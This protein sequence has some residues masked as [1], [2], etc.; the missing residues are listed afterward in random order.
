MSFLIIIICLFALILLITW[1]KLNEFLAFLLV[2]ILAA[3]L[4]GMPMSRIVTSVQ[5]GIGDTLGSLVIILSLGAMLGKLVAQSGAA[6]RIAA[7]LVGMFGRRYIQ[8]A[9]MLTGFIIGIPLFYGVGFVLMIPLIFSVS[10]Q[11]KFPAVYVGMPLL[12]AMSVTHGFLPPHPSPTALVQQFHANM[13]I[14]L[15]Y[16]LLIAVPVII[17]AGPVFSQSLKK[18]VATPLK[19]FQPQENPGKAPGTAVS[20]ITSLL[21]V[22]LLVVAT[23]IPYVIKD[24]SHGFN[25]FLA[26]AGDPAVV[27]LVSVL[28]ATFTLGIGLGRPMKELAPLYADAIKDVSVILLI[29]AG[30]GALKQVLED[31]GVSS[32]IAA[33]LQTWPLHPLVLGWMIAAIIRLCVGSATVAGLTTAGIVSPLLVSTHANPNLMVLAVGAGSLMFS[34]VNDSGFWMFKEYFNVSI[35]DTMRSWSVMETIVSVLGLIGVLILNV[36]I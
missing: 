21:P 13:G 16:G 15:L 34:H 11:Y 19:G 31:S 24:R 29:I 8:W 18:I 26:F 12:A 23:A 7:T 4:F 1:C 5:K 25:S 14:T 20:F 32:E 6:G 2:A 22:F 17:I 3:V 35:K 30:S 28:V 33:T 36:L 10:Y 27:L 9:L